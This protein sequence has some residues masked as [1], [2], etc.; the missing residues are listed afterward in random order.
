MGRANGKRSIRVCLPEDAPLVKLVVASSD[1]HAPVTL[2]R[3]VTLVGSRRDCD[4]SLPNGDISKLHCAIIHTGT[5]VIAVDLCS[6]T[7]TFRAEK[8][9]TVA[10]LSPND[11]LWLGPVEVR[12]EFDASPVSGGAPANALPRLKLIQDDIDAHSVELPAIIG[13]RGKCHAVVDTP[14]VSL[15]HAVVF[16]IQGMPA[17]WD[18][19]SRSGTLLNGERVEAAWL[20]DEDELSIGGEV[21]EL[22]WSGNSAAQL[23]ESS[24]DA[25]APLEG[26]RAEVEEERDPEAARAEQV[27]QVDQATSTEDRVAAASP[28]QIAP[29]PAKS[30]AAPLPNARPRVHAQAATP[31]DAATESVIAAGASGGLEG[32]L[33]ALREQLQSSQERIRQDSETLAAREAALGAQVSA[34]DERATLL[35]EAEEELARDRAQMHEEAAA[36]EARFVDWEAG[37]SQRE[38]ALGALEADCKKRERSLAGREH[39]LAA[40][41][42]KVATDRR[43]IASEREAF[44]AARLEFDT[45][46]KALEV[47]AQRREAELVAGRNALT[48]AESELAKAQSVLQSREGAVARREQVVEES[49][50]AIESQVAELAEQDAALCERADAITQREAELARQVEALAKQQS[51]LDEAASLVQAQQA[52]QN[53]AVEQIEQFKQALM[54]A[55]SSLTQMD[56]ASYTPEAP[57]AGEL[58]EVGPDAAEEQPMDAGVPAAESNVDDDR[59]SA[60][61]PAPLVEEPLFNA[62]SERVD[63]AD[64]P[65]ELRERLAVLRRV[66]SKSEEELVAQV[67]AEQASLAQRAEEESKQQKKSK[68]RWWS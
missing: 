28:K 33:A 37:L 22:A 9:V 58:F 13:R 40:A 36:E 54:E 65:P 64:L 21:F 63:P 6:R 59:P 38:E 49:Q 52:E 27:G 61:L 57:H 39:T 3:P 30:P 8:R 66:S 10:E 26:V 60:D 44:E 46:Q 42:K 50:A 34:L 18:L 29:Q 35:A 55:Q 41:Q 7:G 16:D 12:V 48:R 51:A 5:R 25:A 15:T 68:K 19:G 2:T 45:K 24:V 62:D 1:E 47:D 4:L 32:M 14:D 56:V 20:E 53:S 17:I 31:M 43:Q 67:L 11:S 23:A